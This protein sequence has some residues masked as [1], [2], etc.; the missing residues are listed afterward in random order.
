M[1][2]TTVA[3]DQQSNDPHNDEQ[4]DNRSAASLSDGQERDEQFD[5]TH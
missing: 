1:I 4:V 2:S 3:P 5:Q